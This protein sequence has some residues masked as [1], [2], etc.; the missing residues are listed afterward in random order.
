MLGLLSLIP[1]KDWLYGA[2]LAAA[3]LFCLHIY[4]AGEAKV[5]AEVTHTAQVAQAKDAALEAQA[6]STETQSAIIFKQAV[7]I[8]AVA[9]IGLVCKRTG[10]SPLPAANAQP[11]AGPGNQPADST[12]GPQFDPS[13]AALAR[14]KAADAQIAYLQ[15]RVKELETQM[16]NSP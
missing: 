9:D 12:I 7:S 10:G 13:G 2:L 8:P 6:Q 16:N 4:H 11:G 1:G 15:R 3:G 5:A 14:A